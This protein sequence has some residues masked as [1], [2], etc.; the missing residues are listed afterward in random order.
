MS[1]QLLVVSQVNSALPTGPRGDG[2]TEIKQ[3]F[4]FDP[5]T[6]SDPNLLYPKQNMVSQ[7]THTNYSPKSAC[8]QTFPLH[9]V[10]TNVSSLRTV[11][12]TSHVQQYILYQA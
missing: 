11:Q 7:P 2:K 10:N 9:A 1:L 4:I 3:S 6:A 5:Q 12:F 8:A